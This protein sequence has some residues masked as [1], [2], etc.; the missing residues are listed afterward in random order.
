MVCQQ[1]KAFLRLS[2][3]LYRDVGSLQVCG[4]GHLL[5]VYGHAQYE[6]QNKMIFGIT[7]YGQA[8]KE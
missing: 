5:S 1:K 8:C 2:E 3:A 4:N 7:C 6:R